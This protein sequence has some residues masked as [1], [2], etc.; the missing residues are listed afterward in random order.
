MFLKAWPLCTNTRAKSN[1]GDRVLDEIEKDSFIPLPGKG[2]HTRL[3]SQKAMYL[4]PKELNEGFYNSKSK[5]G[6][7]TR[8]GCMQVLQG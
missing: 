6:S 1:L 2:R 8:L 7:L 3:L 4:N 5:V